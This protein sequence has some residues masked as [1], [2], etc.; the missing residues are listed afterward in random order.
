MHFVVRAQIS[1]ET[2]FFY[3]PFVEHQYYVYV[4][5]NRSKTIY[6]G[7]TNGLR[8]RVIQHKLGINVGFTKR[9]KIDRLVYKLW[10]CS[11]R[12]CTGKRDQV[13]ASNQKDST[14]RQHES[15]VEGPGS[16]IMAGT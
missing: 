11:R 13:L 9:Y 10:V 2:A 14:D 3:M 6:T 5:S 1:L 12:Y 4:M 16:G 8:K 7:L 15:L